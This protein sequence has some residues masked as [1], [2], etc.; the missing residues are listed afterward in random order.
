MVKT[1]YSYLLSV[2]RNDTVAP[3]G[4]CVGEGAIEQA[5]CRLTHCTTKESGITPLRYIWHG[6]VYIFITEGSD[7]NMYLQLISL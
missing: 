1:D 6:I 3:N 4:T 2:W 7:K 5:P